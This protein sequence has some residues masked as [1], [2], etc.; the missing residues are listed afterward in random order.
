MTT[1]KNVWLSN[2]S[3]D[4]ETKNTNISQEL[5]ASFPKMEFLAWS[6]SLIKAITITK[7]KKLVKLIYITYNNT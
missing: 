4:F 2:C 6:Y 7:T 3:T 1:S 5:V